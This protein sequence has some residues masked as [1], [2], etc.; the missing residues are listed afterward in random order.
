MRFLRLKPALLAAV[1]AVA[2]LAASFA[3]SAIIHFALRPETNV[4]VFDRVLWCLYFPA[5]ISTFLCLPGTSFEKGLEQPVQ[6]LVVF[7]LFAL[8]QWYLIFWVGISIRRRFTRKD[9]ETS[10]L[11]EPVA[12]PKGGPATQLDNSGVT[13]GPPSVS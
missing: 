11:A 7:I 2:A 6:I 13:K 8:L 3:L 5:A 10:H 12:A 9:H 4:N 1:F